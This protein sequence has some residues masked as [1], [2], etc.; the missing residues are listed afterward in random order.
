MIKRSIL[1]SMFAAALVTVPAV[2]QDDEAE[3]PKPETESVKKSVPKTAAFAPLPFCRQVDGAAEVQKPMG[4]WEPAEEG[5][6]YPLGSSFRA[7]AEC[8]LE[9][10]FGAESSARIANG[11]EFATVEQPY[12][13]P[14]R[15]L[16]LRSGTVDLKLA[17][18][19]PDGAF[20]VLA[21]GFKVKNP[22]GESKYVMEPN[23]DGEKITVRCVTGTLGIEGRHF[24]IPQMRAADEIVI[25][26]SH[27]YLSTQ[28]SGTSGDYIVWLDQG[29]RMKEEI[30][31]EGNRKSVSEPAKSEWHLSPSTRVVINRALPAIGTRMS[32]FVIAFDAA[33]ERK[34]EF[35]FCEGRAEINSGELVVKEKTDGEEL[36]KRAAEAAETTESADVEDESAEGNKENNTEKSDSEE[37]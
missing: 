35:N 1:C 37:E 5:K 28:L 21:Q 7:G 12:G 3:S 26:S 17:D 9:L 15:T 20:F 31:D 36:A 30:D 32:V 2:A 24:D 29:M 8:A 33:G 13:M 4:E 14:T 18:N 16:V 27:D 19:L 11:S 10:A 6:Y 22:V 25:R 34:S 23:A